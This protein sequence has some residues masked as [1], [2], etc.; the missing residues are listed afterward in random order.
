MPSSNQG[1]FKQPAPMGVGVGGGGMTSAGIGGGAGNV[2]SLSPTNLGQ[3][4]GDYPMRV[5]GPAQGFL[6]PQSHDHQEAFPVRVS[7]DREFRSDGGMNF[8]GTKD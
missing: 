1:L 6:T 5:Q 7:F 4:R 3:H 8:L 2:G